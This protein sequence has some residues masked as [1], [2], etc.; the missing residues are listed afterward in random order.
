MIRPIIDKDG[1]V[2]RSFRFKKMFINLDRE[3]ERELMR[4]HSLKSRKQLRRFIK[5][6]RSKKT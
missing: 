4:R 1:G 5:E 2:V 3:G 6:Q